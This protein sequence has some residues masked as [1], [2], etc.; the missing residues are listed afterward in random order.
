MT[1]LGNILWFVLGGFFSGLLWIFSGLLWC[2]TIIGIPI[3]MQCFKFAELSFFPFGKEIVFSNK[4][5]SMIVNVIWLLFFGWEIALFH[6][7]LG[8]FYCVTII[9]IPFGLQYFK[10]A[11]LALLPFGATIVAKEKGRNHN[12]IDIESQ[13]MLN[14]E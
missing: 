12:S 7:A 11:Y 9:G 13:K 10:L 8:C 3:G 6:V 1:L 14:L 5:S 2:C 4:T